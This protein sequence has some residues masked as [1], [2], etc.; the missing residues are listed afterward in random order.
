MRSTQSTNPTPPLVCSVTTLTIC[1]LLC[2]FF[3]YF[4]LCLY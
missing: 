3:V 1:F 2:L 4:L